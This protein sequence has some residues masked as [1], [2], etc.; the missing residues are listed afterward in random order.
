MTTSQIDPNIDPLRHDDLRA[1]AELEGPVVSFLIPTHRGGPETVDDARQLKPLLSDARAQLAD[2]FPDADADALLAETAGLA[3]NEPFWQQQADAL[4]IFA[5]ASD[6][7]Y[8]RTTL[9]GQAQVSVGEYANLRPLLPLVAD[10]LPFLLLAASEDKVRLFEGDRNHLDELDLGDAPASAG[11][12]DY[13][14]REPQFQHQ[15]GDSAP[16]HGHDTGDD[17]VLE[18]FL[19]DV[20]KSVNKRFTNDNR[21]L[22][23]AAVDEHRGAVKDY[24]PNVDLLNETVSGNPDRL[25]AADLHT[26]AWPLAAAEADKR[27]DDLLERFGENL[28]TGKATHDAAQISQEAEHGRVDTLILSTLA[29]RENTLGDSSKAADLDAAV[30]HTLRNSGTVDVVPAFNDDRP[31]AA[32]FRF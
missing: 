7:R 13:Y 15:T 10:D 4:V 5:S 16:A 21:P 1:I 19:R 8:F 26:K 28:G 23:L 31:A 6:T 3:N 11:D 29:L 20:A 12:S 30:T 32:I 9:S 22:I 18:S 25:S 14:T 24:L 27:H 2:A 17:I